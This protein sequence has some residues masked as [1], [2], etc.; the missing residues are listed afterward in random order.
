M[1]EAILPVTDCVRCD[2]CEAANP[3]TGITLRW[4]GARLRFCDRVCREAWQEYRA[5]IERYRERK[6]WGRCHELRR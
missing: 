4:M 3:P 1:T 6:G 2:F 5:L